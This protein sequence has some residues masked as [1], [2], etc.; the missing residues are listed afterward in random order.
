[1][2]NLHISSK[3][4]VTS[5][6][7]HQDKIICVKV[8]QKEIIMVLYISLRTAKFHINITQSMGKCVYIAVLK[9]YV[10]LIHVK[11]LK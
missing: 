3:E 5:A 9:E 11:A 10:H 8:R 1:M 2:N 6:D 7:L 4:D